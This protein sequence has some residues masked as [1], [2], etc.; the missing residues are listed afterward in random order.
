[1]GDQSHWA[2]QRFDPTLVTNGIE[3][4]DDPV[5]A[6]RARAYAESFARRSREA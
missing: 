2:G 4:S 6:F 3:L 1:V 5:L